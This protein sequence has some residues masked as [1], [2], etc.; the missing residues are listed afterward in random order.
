MAVRAAD[1]ND[2]AP[3]PGAGTAHDRGG[4]RPRRRQQAGAALSRPANCATGSIRRMAICSR[5]S[6]DATADRRLRRRMAGAFAPRA[7]L[8]CARAPRGSSLGVIGASCTAPSCTSR[9]AHRLRYE[10]SSAEMRRDARSSD[11]ARFCSRAMNSAASAPGRSAP[12]APGPIIVR[13]CESARRGA[14]CG[15]RYRMSSG[16]WRA[17]PTGYAIELRAPLESLR[18]AARGV[19][20]RITTTRR[21][22]HTRAPGRLAH[23]LRST[24]ATAH[25]IHARRRCAYRSSM[26]TAGCWPAQD[27]SRSTRNPNYPG[28]RRDENGFMRSIYR[29]LFP[30]SRDASPGIWP[31]LR[32]VGRARGCGTRGHDTAIWFEQAGGEP[33]L[34]RAAVPISYHDEALGASGRRTAGRSNWCWSASWR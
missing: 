26:P 25:A 21:S 15:R 20:H 1:G 33:S 13:A 19:R 7:G 12:S 14:R 34:V 22:H 32:H 10:D 2:V 5:P 9:C 11:R 3:G 30:S 8:R 27:R 18:H 24:E 4:A 6:A 16:V 31:A 17:T 28:L 29:A 23:R